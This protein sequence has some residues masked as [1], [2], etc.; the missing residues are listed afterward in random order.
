MIPKEAVG[1]NCLL[2]PHVQKENARINAA[3]NSTSGY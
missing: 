1:I 2:A 3:K